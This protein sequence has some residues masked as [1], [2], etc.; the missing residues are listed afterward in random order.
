MR[1]L[2]VWAVSAV[3]ESWTPESS[4][5]HRR[6]CIAAPVRAPCPGVCGQGLFGGVGRREG[7]GLGTLDGWPVGLGVGKCVGLGV[8]FPEGAAVGTDDVGSGVGKG[9]GSVDGI[10]VVGLLVGTGVGVVVVGE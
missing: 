6:T 2:Y 1:V 10:G 4:P 5:S 7:F 3:S 9:V 8:G